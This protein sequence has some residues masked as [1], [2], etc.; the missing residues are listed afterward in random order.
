MT[1]RTKMIIRKGGDVYFDYMAEARKN[2]VFRKNVIKYDVVEL[3]KKLNI[4]FDDAKQLL[5]Y[6][7]F[8]EEN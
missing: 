1:R 2:E 5:F 7:M 8:I 6:C 4:S 3:M